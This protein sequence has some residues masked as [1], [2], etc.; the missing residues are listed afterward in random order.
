TALQKFFPRA[1]CRHGGEPLAGRP[2]FFFAPQIVE[3]QDQVG[4]VVSRCRLHSPS[5]LFGTSFCRNAGHDVDV[6]ARTL[7]R[8]SDAIIAAEIAKWREA[9]STPSCGV[10]PP[11]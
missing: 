5:P 9:F 6:T 4:I 1:Q 7:L 3:P 10:R 2:Q 8:R 11:D